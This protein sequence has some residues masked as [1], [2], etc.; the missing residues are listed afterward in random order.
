MVFDKILFN[1][2]NNFSENLCSDYRIREPKDRESLVT[3]LKTLQR[4][5][6]IGEINSQFIG[7]T[8]YDFITSKET[9]DRHTTARIFEDIFG[10]LI[11]VVATDTTRRENPPVPDY[12]K[13]YDSLCI[14]NN[15]SISG[16]L[17]GNKREKADHKIDNYN[18]SIKTLKGQLYDIDGNIIDRDF[19]NE[20]NIGSFS[21]RSLF[22]GLTDRALSDRRG[23]LGSPRQ[24]IPLLNEIKE[25]GYFD[26]FKKR[27]KD[28]VSYIYQDDVLIVFKS[29]YKMR[30]VFIPFDTF[31]KAIIET[32]N[33]ENPIEEFTKIWY[34]WEN[35]NLRIRFTPLLEMI[36]KLNL[37]YDDI[38]LNLESVFKNKNFMDNISLLEKLLDK[39][40]EDL[41]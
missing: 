13:K 5:I 22:I 23:G 2:L 33:Q 32:L 16:D 29:G 18:L 41:I 11:G 31:D 20:I 15:W 25:N 26:E 40:I 36:N 21:H 38:T 28:Y 24:I 1:K 34:R 9:R 10:Q 3:Y 7:L 12:I 19:N 8:L 27:I 17:S 14:G 37:D 4:G 35:N 30:I 6:D 39:K